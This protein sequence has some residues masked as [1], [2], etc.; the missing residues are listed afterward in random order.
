MSATIETTSKR[1]RLYK[2][3]IYVLSFVATFFIYLKTMNPTSFAYDT[4][5]FHIQIP[6]LAVGQP[7]GFPLA[8]LLGKLFTY[9]PFATVAYRLNLFSVFFGA[10][11]V[12]VFVMIVSNLIKKEYYIAFI[13]TLF[14]CLFKVFWLQTNRFEVYTLHTFLTG[15]ILLFGIYWTN[16]KENKF[17][18]L[19]YL[20]IGLSLTNHPLSIFLAPILVV[21][22]II[23]D[24]KAVFKLKKV[25]II[26]I[27]VLAPLLFYLYIPIRSLQGYGKIKTVQQFFHYITGMQWKQQFG[28]RSMAVLKKQ[29]LGYYH[30]IYQDF[31]IAA[32]LITLFGF[33]MLAVKR[34]K[35][36][37]LVL[38]LILLNLIPVFLYEDVPNDFYI[39]SV[40]TFLILPFAFGVYY[41]KEAVQKV[42]KKVTEKTLKKRLAA[43]NKLKNKKDLNSEPG[44]FR[45][46][47]TA[48]LFSAIL[49]FPVN[50]FALN[51]AAVDKSHDTKI[52][53][54]WKNIESNLEN[55]SIFFSSSKS[56]NVLMYLLLYESDK[57]VKIESGLSYEKMLPV[58]KENIGKS[59][60]YFN[61]AYLPDFSNAFDLEPV[62]YSLYWPDY[63]ESLKTYKILGAK[64]YVEFVTDNNA[65]SFKFGEEKSISYT[66][67][68]KSS[69]EPVHMDSIELG[70]PKCLSL[71]GIDESLSDIKVMPGMAKGF[72]MWTE[73]PYTIE[74]SGE[75]TISIKVKAIA[76]DEN[77]IEFK[78]TT[79]NLYVEAPEMAVKIN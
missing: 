11:T 78:I 10:A 65:V 43:E 49:F 19:Y 8:F 21:F 24:Y 48:I 34:W 35:Y 40:I 42:F 57:K 60:L 63:S 3:T 29:A 5:W 4:T 32:A 54:Y 33:V 62:G 77:K 7:T 68:N 38:F 12:T 50:V 41:I 79:N 14:F 6:Q 39:V 73:G 64:E 36:F 46:N 76:P 2:F 30:L 9:L 69:D 31:N 22:P 37:I 25:I 13:S 55:N 66:I 58:I 15:L 72:Y 27:L 71:V 74:P 52:Y 28:F 53:D 47:F 26:I 23:I 61:R 75:L 44:S 51:Y 18:Y 56:T 67:K 16:T 45:I 59:T 70:L 1:E 20:F 17:L